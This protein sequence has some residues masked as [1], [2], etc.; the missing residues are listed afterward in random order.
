MCL[1]YIIIAYMTL[2]FGS[3]C[4]LRYEHLLTA[5]IK[6]MGMHLNL[7]GR[8]L[9][10]KD[11]VCVATLEVMNYR[12][13]HAKRRWIREVDISKG[14][15]YGIYESPHDSDSALDFDER[16]YL[17]YNF[18]YQLHADGGDGQGVA[19]PDDEV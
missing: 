1:P 19:P 2:T 9:S 18:L 3:G 7:G 5:F 4:Y 6:A 10:L 14:E 15:R 13:I 8:S 11:T 16:D 17:D 12:Y